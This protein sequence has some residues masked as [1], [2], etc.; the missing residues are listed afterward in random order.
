MSPSCSRWRSRSAW[1]L[2]RLR[3]GSS[4]SSVD[5]RVPGVGVGEVRDSAQPAS[6]APQRPRPRDLGRGVGRHRLARVGHGALLG[7]VRPPCRLRFL[8]WA[9]LCLRGCWR[10]GRAVV[11]SGPVA[12][13]GAVRV[14]PVPAP[15]VAG[16]KRWAAPGTARRRRGRPRRCT[17]RCPPRSLPASTPGAGR[18]NSVCGTCVHAAW[19][20]A[21]LASPVASSAGV[22]GAGCAG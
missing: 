1:V 14:G 3:S 16:G 11:G 21:S 19:P 17:G 10:A 18:D 9:R 20:C 15:V 6:S 2:V 7:R 4:A 22:P 5:S 8:R 13:A 12:V